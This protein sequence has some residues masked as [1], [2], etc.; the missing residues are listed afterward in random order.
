MIFF[1]LPAKNVT[2]EWKKKSLPS[3]AQFMYKEGQKV[4]NPAKTVAG[5]E[6]K[7]H[8]ASI[9][10]SHANLHLQQRWVLPALQIYIEIN[11]KKWH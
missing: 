4:D 2:L 3:K 11:S 9:T 7:R 5:W 8:C 6:Q 1:F 10:I